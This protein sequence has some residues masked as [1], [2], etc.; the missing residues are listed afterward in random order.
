MQNRKDRH[1]HLK[2]F[3]DIES[4]RFPSE[5]VHSLYEDIGHLINIL[6]ALEHRCRGVHMIDNPPPL[7]V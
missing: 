4:H 3:A 1:I 2:L 5:L 6:F 7:G